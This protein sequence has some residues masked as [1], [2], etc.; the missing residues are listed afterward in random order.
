MLR[1]TLCS[2]IKR[3]KGL[4]LF[5]NGMPIVGKIFR[6]VDKEETGAF[7]QGKG[8]R[9]VLSACFETQDHWRV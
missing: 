1:G 8:I 5:L 4:L 6:H 9:L 2:K 3:P 7:L